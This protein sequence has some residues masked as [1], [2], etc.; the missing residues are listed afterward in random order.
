M[1]TSPS[2]GRGGLVRALPPAEQQYQ[3]HLVT[4]GDRR[5]ELTSLEGELAQLREAVTGFEAL[6][7][8]RLGQ[9]FANL[10]QNSVRYTDAPGTIAVRLHRNADSIVVDWEDSAPGVPENT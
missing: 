10:L 1:E 3:R 6:A 8:S 4:I 9:L 5:R 2:N 7:Q